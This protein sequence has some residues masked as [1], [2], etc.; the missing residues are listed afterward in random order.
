MEYWNALDGAAQ[1]ASGKLSDIINIIDP[2][3]LH[4]NKGLDIFLSV[5]SMGITLIPGGG[6][7]AGS[8]INDVGK[9]LISA[10]SVSYFATSDLVY[11]NVY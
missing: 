6:F 10:A 4:Q 8:A 5:L 2:P 3:K 9:S 1:G 7:L 11:S